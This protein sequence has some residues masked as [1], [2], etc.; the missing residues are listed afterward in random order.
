MNT[1]SNTPRKKRGLLP[2]AEPDD[3]PS[4]NG[5]ANASAEATEL[6]E[7]ILYSNLTLTVHHKEKFLDDQLYREFPVPGL[8]SLGSP[9]VEECILNLIHTTNRDG[10]NRAGPVPSTLGNEPMPELASA[11]ESN[12]DPFKDY[13]RTA[14]PTCPHCNLP[15]AQCIEVIYGPQMKHHF[16]RAALT[17]GP[18]YYLEEEKDEPEVVIRRNFRKLLTQLKFATAVMN[19]TQMPNYPDDGSNPFLS[20]TGIIESPLPQCVID[21]S[22][23]KFENWLNEQKFVHE[24]GYDISDM[25]EANAVPMEVVNFYRENVERNTGP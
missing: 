9:A 11:V 20:D 18:I 16:Q 13:S 25:T 19:G 1:S 17:I 3:V 10:S 15:R 5:K 24:W 12:L 14:I 21:G 6:E 23:T 8:E 4:D 22:C 2:K 7:C